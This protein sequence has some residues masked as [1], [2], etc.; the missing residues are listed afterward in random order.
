M[1]IESAPEI[2]PTRSLGEEE[3]RRRESSDRKI[4]SQCRDQA[5]SVYEGVVFEVKRRFP[6][7][8]VLS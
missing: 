5:R 2:G 6:L 7:N 3:Y 8:V 4:V 1:V